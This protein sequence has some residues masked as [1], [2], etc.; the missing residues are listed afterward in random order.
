MRRFLLVIWPGLLLVGCKDPVERGYRKDD[1]SQAGSSLR[2]GH[3]PR[4]QDPEHPGALREIYEAAIKIESPV[5]REKALA[6]VAWNALEIDPDLAHEAF[7]Q[8]PANSPEKIRL[9]QH[10]AMRLAEQDPDE[11][12]AWADSL[13]TDQ[14]IAA[15][16]EQIA[17]VIAES[18]PHRAANLISESGITGREFDVAVVQVIQRW[19]AKSAPDA[20]AWVSSFPQG[21]AREAGIRIIAEKWLPSDAPAAFNWLRNMSDTVIRKE[22]ARA[23]EGVI[24]QQP[25]DIRDTW[26]R[27][28]DAGIRRELEEQL[29]NAINDVGDN[30]PPLAE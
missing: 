5:V 17:L 9:I 14:E 13:G 25:Q 30:I 18:D 4:G 28:A 12:L 11:A 7:R 20:A 6:D 2:S 15:A 29:G 1:D 26:L 27:Q 19:A 10:Y 24:L 22:T 23:M 3:A 16:K 8:L 21:E